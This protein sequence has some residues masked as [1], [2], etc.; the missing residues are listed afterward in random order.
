[1]RFKVRPGDFIV[2]EQARLPLDASGGFA[3][4]LVEKQDVTTQHVQHHI[5]AQLK[6]RSSDVQTPALK[7]KK[8]VAVQHLS[9]RGTGPAEL[10]GP[11]YH[12]RF[13][14]I[15]RHPLRP[16]DL[17]GNRFTVTLRDL[18]P[19]E[20][21]IIPE[22]LQ[23]LAHFGLPNY[24]DEQRFGSYM[25]QPNAP[26]PFIGKT[27]LRRDA[28]NAIR[29]YLSVP[30]AGD[31]AKVRAF[32]KV[33]QAHWGEWRVLM[34]KAPRPSNYRS[35]LTFL[36]D[37]PQGF[38]K[39]LNLIPR[40]LLSLYLVAYQSYLWNQLAAG[41][42]TH[43]LGAKETFPALSLVDLTLPLYRELSESQY[44]TLKKASIPLPE[45]RASYTDPVLAQL[46]Q[47]VLKAQG[48]ELNDLKA[49]ILKKAYVSKGHRA[50]LLFPTDVTSDAPQNDVAFP[51]RLAIQFRFTLPRGAFAT[52]VLK[53]I[54]WAGDV[55][56]VP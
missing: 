41:Y 48:F 40:R 22:Q 17:T 16:S 4:Y 3:V 26:D 49:R 18:S 50:L 14:G 1:M 10:E 44:G 51:G 53:W 5:A 47:N 52:L 6:L 2:E 32:K 46:A 54:V 25:S 9:V 56:A 30:F 20:A 13:I 19:T 31:P 43:H 7:D 39:A 23:R 21:Q 33:A 36:Q 29:A 38:R 27:I 28:E 11:G 55:K 12:A 34:S 15:S 45:H 8:A 37:H 24:F 42:L 35:V